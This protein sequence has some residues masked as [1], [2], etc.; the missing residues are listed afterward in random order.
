VSWNNWPEVNAQ[1]RRSRS[2]IRSLSIFSSVRRD[3]MGF[4]VMAGGELGHT[5]SRKPQR[6]RPGTQI[7]K[8]KKK[9]QRPL[10]QNGKATPLAR[11][12]PAGAGKSVGGAVS[13]E[14]C[15]IQARSLVQ[16]L[17]IMHCRLAAASVP[18]S[19]FPEHAPE[20]RR[21][22]SPFRPHEEN[23]RAQGKSST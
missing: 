6:Y 19:L 13:A 14:A 5:I 16:T 17:S 10:L 9:F 11:R 2:R 12:Q 7:K 15:Q 23:C 8:D 3:L 20:K 22:W 18:P 21:P 1:H 4:A